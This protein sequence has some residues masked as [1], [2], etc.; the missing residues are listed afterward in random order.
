[1]VSR[2]EPLRVMR[3]IARMNVGGPALQ[4]VTLLR[5]LPADEF[6]QRL[7]TGFVGPG[8]ADYIDLRAP[9]L[10]VHR[11]P[12]LGRRIRLAD[13]A[14]ALASLAD[15]MRRFRPHIVHTHT[16]KAGSLG[17]AAAILARA[18]GRVHTFHGHLLHGYFPART[19]RLVVAAERLARQA[20]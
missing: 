3:I 5:G 10:E 6:E 17:R 8:E 15:Q 18:P 16:A 14:R 13:D 9:G 11:V 7:Y 4:A 2:I 12:A 19:A 20:H 1:M